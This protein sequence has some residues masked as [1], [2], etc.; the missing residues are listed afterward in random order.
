MCF[1]NI[2]IDIIVI[3]ECIEEDVNWV[4]HTWDEKLM[5]TWPFKTKNNYG[6][7]SLQQWLTLSMINFN[8]N[9][10]LWWQTL[11]KLPDC[12]TPSCPDPR[13]SPEMEQASSSQKSEI[14]NYYCIRNFLINAWWMCWILVLEMNKFTLCL[15]VV[16]HR[17]FHLQYFVLARTRTSSNIFVV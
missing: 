12:T 7:I 3:H 2:W 17:C 15:V 10:P 13:T 8:T 9:S 5:T 16:L 6:S 14:I 11:Q 1:N 4:S